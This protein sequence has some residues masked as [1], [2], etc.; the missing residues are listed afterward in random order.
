M[1]LIHGQTTDVFLLL[2]LPD[3]II[4]APTEFLVVVGDLG[5]ED[6]LPS[7]LTAQV[8]VHEVNLRLGPGISA[9][10]ALI[11]RVRCSSLVQLG[12]DLDAASFVL[13]SLGLEGVDDAPHILS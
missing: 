9:S 1:N 5:M 11:A 7:H 8:A 12:R 13:H 10:A 4:H 6:L 3:V 2:I